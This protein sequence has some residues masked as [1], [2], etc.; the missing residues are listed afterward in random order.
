MRTLILMLLASLTLAFTASA[1]EPGVKDNAGL[2][3]PETVEKVNAEIQQIHKD[4]GKELVIETYPTVPESLKSD[5]EAVKDD[6]KKRAEFFSK[7]LG[8]RA[9]ELQVNGVYVL[10]V[11]D[12]GH[13]EVKAGLKTKAKAFTEANQNKMRDILLE[14][15]K[16]ERYD[17]GLQKAVDYFREALKENLGGVHHTGASAA[18]D[19]RFHHP[20]SGNS[21]GSSYSTPYRPPVSTPRNSF[22]SGS[23][24]WI[25]LVII[26]AVVII[27][28]LSGLGS[29][30]RNYGGGP[31]YGPGYGGGGYG[32]GYGGG[33][34]GGGFFRNMLGG[35][36]GGAAGGYLYDRF[37]DRNE[38]TSPP[39]NQGGVMPDNSSGGDFGSSTPDDN[40][41]GQGF[42]GGGS[43]GDFGP[44]DSG[45][46]FG[47]SDSGSSGGDFGGGGGGDSGGGGGDSGGSG[48]D[49]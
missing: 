14:E 34:G 26:A 37:R 33:G 25:V 1:A 16:A 13:L 17:E 5:Y 42:G 10:V 30:P 36:L 49:F 32:G 20:Q 29:G 18:P 35:I 40:D 19:E 7:W 46:S 15:F 6:P 31:G 11:K 21:S 2:F 43:A 9:H 12:P 45:S 39:Q 23:C 27:R 22:F 44:S 3:K 4:F 28:I 38:G 47:S 24:M 48:G 8:D 41:R